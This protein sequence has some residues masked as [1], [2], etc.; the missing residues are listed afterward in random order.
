M[1]ATVSNNQ[2]SSFKTI[3]IGVP[4]GSVL[5]PLLFLVYMNDLPMHTA[6]RCNMY[7]DDTLLFCTDLALDTCIQ[8]LQVEVDKVSEWFKSNRLT[9][10]VAKSN[11]MLSGSRQ[12][13]QGAAEQ[14]DVGITLDNMPILNTTEYDYLG[15]RLDSHIA[16]KAHIDKVCK[17]LSSRVGMLQRVKDNFTYSQRNALYYAFV[18][19]SIDYALS[20]W[21]NTTLSNITRIQRFQNR[22][23]RIVTN[24]FNFDIPSNLLIQQ[25]RWQTVAVRR[26]FLTCILMYKCTNAM[27]PFYLSDQFTRAN[28]VHDHSTRQA[29]EDT[30]YVPWAR[31]QY[32]ERSLAVTGPT[33][34]N[35]LPEHIRQAQ[36]LNSFKCNYKRHF[37]TLQI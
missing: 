5:G 17:S 7:A 9:L 19:P 14:A 26:N 11:T 25:L 23:A 36:S 3:N 15:V 8:S 24:N 16:W 28:V 31:T 10:N 34:W 32:Y 30:L 1:H 33:L 6:A 20:I 18:Q 27:A 4:Q 29:V 37:S 35:N 22:A 13:L 21:G 2:L 12:R